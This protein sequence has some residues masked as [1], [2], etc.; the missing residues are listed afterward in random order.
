MKTRTVCRCNN[1]QHIS[2]DTKCD[3]IS[4]C[5]DGSDEINCM[6]IIPVA[7]P[8]YVK[9]PPVVV[10]MDRNRNFFLTAMVV[11]DP[12]PDTHFRCPQPVYCMPVF[13]R[14]NGVKDCPYGEDEL[15]CKT[16]LCPGYYRCRRSSVC[17]H[18]SHVCDGMPQCPQRDDELLCNASCPSVCQCQGLAFVCHQPFPAS[19]Y[20]DLRYLDAEFPCSPLDMRSRCRS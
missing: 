20:P 12:C 14:C 1:G 13:L 17:L 9:E 5:L 7:L 10:S 16:V 18:P 19:N 3:F 4:D 11:S 15:S 8:F 2:Q 6:G